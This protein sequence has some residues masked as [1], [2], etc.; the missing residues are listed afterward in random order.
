[1]EG[2]RKR[3]QLMSHGLKVW[4][5][6]MVISTRCHLSLGLGGVATT[7]SGKEVHP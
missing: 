5:S 1:M 6:D 3:I 2:T 4:L 7:L